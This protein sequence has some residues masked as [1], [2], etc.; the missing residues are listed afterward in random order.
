MAQKAATLPYSHTCGRDEAAPAVLSGRWPRRP[1]SSRR[2]A[3]WR[4][5][6]PPRH[7]SISPLQRPR[8][9]RM[10]Q[11]RVADSGLN[12]PGRGRAARWRTVAITTCLRRRP[13]TIRRTAFSLRRFST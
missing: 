2:H 13:A 12:P 7:G 8:A 6:L 9:A 11:R 1:D 4:Y 3:G 5:R 10:P